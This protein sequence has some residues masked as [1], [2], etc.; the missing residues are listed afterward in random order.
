[1]SV[2]IHLTID[3]ANLILMAPVTGSYGSA[4]RIKLKEDIKDAFK[5][6]GEKAEAVTFT[7]TPAELKAWAA[8]CSAGWAQ[9]TVATR[10]GPMPLTDGDR[11]LLRLSAKA[12][13][14]WGAVSKTLPKVEEDAEF[15][16]DVDDQI[17]LD[18][19]V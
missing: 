7:A 9:E 18:A 4:E 12:L 3:Q 15:E 8:G 14:V 5:Q 1:M 11:N 13:K 10:N 16:I 2:E 19:E 6:A 17:E